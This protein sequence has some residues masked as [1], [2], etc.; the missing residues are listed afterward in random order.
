MS[1]TAPQHPGKWRLP[2]VRTVLSA[3]TLALILIGVISYFAAPWVAFRALRNAA[4]SEDV[5]AMSELMELGSVRTGLRAQASPNGPAPTPNFLDDPVGALRGALGGRLPGE[6]SADVEGYLTPSGLE[7][8]SGARAGGNGRKFR[9]GD[10]LPGL[11]DSEI[12]YWG[13]DTVR[14]A[15]LTPGNGDEEAVF[16]LERRGFFKW[17]VTHIRLPEPVA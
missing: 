17:R 7:H 3:L 13:A 2:R 14:V 8:L 4:I 9:I 5:S 15:T 11:H 10:L 16:T 6:A 1:E 12:R